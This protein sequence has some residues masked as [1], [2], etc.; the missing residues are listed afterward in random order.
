MVYLLFAC[1]LACTVTGAA[2][3]A[4]LALLGGALAAFV[5]PFVGVLLPACMI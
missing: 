1:A 3:A 2:A 4:L 5:R